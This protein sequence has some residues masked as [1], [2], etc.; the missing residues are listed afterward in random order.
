MV[1]VGVGVVDRAGTSVNSKNGQVTPGG[2]QNGGVR[3]IASPQFFWIWGQLPMGPKWGVHVVP[4]MWAHVGLVAHCSL[5][6]RNGWRGCPFVGDGQW[7]HWLWKEGMGNGWTASLGWGWAMGALCGE[8][9][10]RE[11]WGLRGKD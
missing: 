5:G 6:L 9:W 4:P 3:K 2:P 11:G 10:D 7:R 8:G 1:L